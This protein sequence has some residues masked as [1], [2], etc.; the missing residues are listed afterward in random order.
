MMWRPSLFLHCVGI[1]SV[2]FV[3]W[4]GE[5]GVV[6]LLLLCSLLAATEVAGC[7]LLSHIEGTMLYLKPI[8]CTLLEHVHKHAATSVK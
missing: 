1:V 4:E 3:K 6:F 8:L 2:V 7:S 5:F